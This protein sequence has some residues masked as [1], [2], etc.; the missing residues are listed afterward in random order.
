MR[1]TRREPP[2]IPELEADALRQRRLAANVDRL[3]V[4]YR[5]EKLRIAERAEGD[6]LDGLRVESG[7]SGALEVEQQE[8]TVEQ[9]KQSLR[10]RFGQ[11]TP[12]RLWVFSETRLG[13]G[14]KGADA[15]AQTADENAFK[16]AKNPDS[17]F[18]PEEWTPAPRRRTVS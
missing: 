17:D 12:P 6:R 16:G 14:G 15:L 3:A 2:T 18:Q 11:S 7:R 10:Q 1:R 5:E 8:Q 4:E 9:Q 13:K